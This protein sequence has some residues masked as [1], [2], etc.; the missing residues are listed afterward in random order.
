MSQGKLELIPLDFEVSSMRSRYE[1]LKSCNSRIAYEKVIRSEP[2][3][4]GFFIITSENAFNNNCKFLSKTA[5]KKDELSL[6]RYCDQSISSAFA[7]IAEK[8]SLPSSI[9]IPALS[10]RSLYNDQGLFILPE[11]I[12]E[13][14]SIFFRTLM[15]I[16]SPNASIVKPLNPLPS[17]LVESP[18]LLEESLPGLLQDMVN[19]LNST[20]RYEVQLARLGFIVQTLPNDPETYDLLALHWLSRIMFYHFGKMEHWRDIRNE[21]LRATGVNIITSLQN[22]GNFVDRVIE[23]KVKMSMAWGK[24]AE[25]LTAEEMGMQKDAESA[26]SE[27]SSMAREEMRAIV[28]LYVHANAL[29]QS[30][31]NRDHARVRATEVMSTL[32]MFAELSASNARQSQ[33]ESTSAYLGSLSEIVDFNTTAL[34]EFADTLPAEL[35]TPK[36]NSDK[37]NPVEKRWWKKR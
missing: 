15:N 19:Y 9:V 11:H 13:S 7:G 21:T 35:T 22:A 29:S 6:V 14:L 26:L 27:M 28:T 30:L 37:K 16:N 33:L 3:N 1:K 4:E 36:N 20:Y 8:T 31:V 17:A 18:H 12:D 34:L 32:E 23:R 5:M 25:S 24:N 10:N 2:T